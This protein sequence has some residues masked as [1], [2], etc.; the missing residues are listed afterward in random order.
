MAENSREESKA[1]Q[2]LIIEAVAAPIILGALLLMSPLAS[3]SGQWTDPLTA[4]FMSTSAM[5]VTGHAIVDTGSYFST[6]GQ[7]VLL[8]LQLPVIE[9]AV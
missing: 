3:A 1:P 2:W 9:S 5:C 7:L 4:L 8:A 6:F